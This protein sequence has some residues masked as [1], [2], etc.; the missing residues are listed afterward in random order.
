MDSKVTRGLPLLALF[1]VFV[2]VVLASQAARAQTQNAIAVSFP[3]ATQT[4]LFGINNKSVMVGLYVDAQ[5]NTHGLLLQNGAYTS[6]DYP[7]AMATEAHGINDNGDVVG[8]YISDNYHGFL[9]SQGQY[10]TIDVPFSNAS[11]TWAHG[12]NSAG[13][14]VAAM[15]IRLERTMGSF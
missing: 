10:T 8:V 14:I 3:G 15:R 5:N 12:I 13:Q 1:T 2:A 4:E 7:G 11:Y 6:L 9:F